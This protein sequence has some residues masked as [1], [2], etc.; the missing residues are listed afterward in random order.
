MGSCEPLNRARGA[1]EITLQVYKYQTGLLLGVY[2][3]IILTRQSYPRW[4]APCQS[5]FPH[6]AVDSGSTHFYIEEL[7][8]IN[9]ERESGTKERLE[10]WEGC[11]WANKEQEVPGGGRV[12]PQAQLTW[13]GCAAFV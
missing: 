5:A 4:W 13:L 11:T 1:R 6:P 3:H 12:S 7:L 8:S 2:G 9:N 10:H